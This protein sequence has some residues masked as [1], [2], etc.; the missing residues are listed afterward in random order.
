[1]ATTR[2]PRPTGTPGADARIKELKSQ[3]ERDPFNINLRL[4]LSSAYDAAGKNEDAVKLLKDTVEKA[5]R[6]LGVAY[7]TLAQNLLKVNRPDEALTTFDHAIDLDPGNATFYVSLKAAAMRKL[8]MGDRANALFQELLMRK[9][10]A[11]ETRRIVLQN[12][13]DLK[14]K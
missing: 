3:M 11:K 6:N 1:M 5:K 9:D 10:L 14:K 12:L 8:G 2:I 13:E 7:S 4:M